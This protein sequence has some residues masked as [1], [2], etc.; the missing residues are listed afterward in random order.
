[1]NRANA[2]ILL[3]RLQVQNA[4]AVSGPLSWGFPSPT[5]F[6][7]FAHALQR[8]LSHLIERGF[9]GV[10]IVC[11]RFDPQVSRP[12]GKRTKVFNLTRNPL[13]KGGNSA[14]IVEE[15]RAHMEVSLVIALY[16]DIDSD[17]QSCFAE[18]VMEAAHGMRLAGGSILPQ[19]SGK[20]YGADYV[21]LSPALSERAVTYHKL[22]RRLLP[23]FMLIQRE[24]KLAKHLDEM[25]KAGKGSHTLD[26]LLD[27]SRINFEPDLLDEDN[28]EEHHW[29]IRKHSGWLVPIPVGYAGISPL[30]SPGE[31]R[32]SRD[33]ETPMRFVESL[34]SLGEWISPHRVG[35]LGKALWH[36]QTDVENGIYLCTSHYVDSVTTNEISIHKERS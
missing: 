30:Y 4:N 19:R 32:N 16:D 9:G 29:G 1:M 2:L 20:R 36:Q 31:V 33:A 11:H 27:L 12:A 7:G 34:Y 10:G 21:S 18:Q 3:P 5:A 15:G 8:R 13:G 35:D 6:V 23:G 25:R 26:A 17:D 22:T 14:S 28:P 24:D